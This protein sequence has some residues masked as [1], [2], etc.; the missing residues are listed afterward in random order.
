MKNFL[1]FILALG[2][3]ALALQAQ[4]SNLPRD[5]FWVTDGEVR[6][7][8]ETN[9]V[10][11]VGG[12]F[13]YVSP[14]SETGAAFD[15]ISGATLFDFPKFAGTIKVI[16]GDNAGGWFVGGQFASVGG[17]AIA[18]LAHILS[19]H[20]VDTNWAPNPDGSVLSL[21]ISADKLFVGGTFNHIGGKEHSGLAALDPVLSTPMENWTCNL[22]SK[23]AQASANALTL[24][25]GLLYVGGLFS[26]VNGEPR[27]HLASVRA[28]DGAVTSWYPNGQTGAEVSTR[29]NA[30]A[31]ADKILYVGGTFTSIGSE[32]SDGTARGFLAAM[33]TTTNLPY[34]VTSWNP[35]ANGPVT[36]IAI[37]CDTVYVAGSFTS[38]GGKPRNRLAAVSIYDGTPTAWD[39]NADNDVLSLTLAGNTIYVGGKFSHV[40]GQ[41]RNFLAALDT[42]TGTATLWNPKS[43]FGVAG[44]F[45]S[46]SSI[47]A[48]GV[49]GPGGELRHNAAAFNTRTGKPLSWSPQV[50]GATILNVAPFEGVK[51]FSTSSNLVY[52]GGYF[53]KVDELE[54]KRIATFNA[55]SGVLGAWKPSIEGFTETIL[56]GAN[57][58][59]V[60]GYFSSAAGTMRT[61]LAALD[62]RTGLTLP[63]FDPHPDGKVTSLAKTGR[64]LYAAGNFTKIGGRTRKHLAA[65]DL[66][67]GEPSLWNPQVNDQVSSMALSGNRLYV[68]GVFTKIGSEAV[69]G[70]AAVDT[71]TGEATCWRPEPQFRSEAKN[72]GINAIVLSGNLVYVA[73]TFDHIGGQ[74][75]HSL[76]ALTTECSA[77]A[78]EWDPNIGEAVGTIALSRDSLFAGG[79]FQTVGGVYRPSLAVFAPVGAPRI[80][81]QPRSQ[82]VGSGVP[83]LLS[84]L[85]EG[86][87]PLAFQWEKDGVPI[88]GANGPALSLQNPNASDSGDYTLIVTNALGLVSSR[89]AAL[90]ILEPVSITAQ[91]SGATVAAGVSLNLT[92]KVSGNPQPIYQWRKNG[93]NI[94][95]AIFSTLLL[96]NAQPFDGG[97]YSV[98]VLGLRNA[99]V[100]SNA[101]VIVQAPVLPFEDQLSSR[102]MLV[103]ESG[104]GSGNN[105]TATAEPFEP[106]HARKFGGKSVWLS[107]QAPATGV[108]TFSTA[109]SGFDTLLGIYTG[110]SMGALVP[111]AAD[112][113]HGGYLTSEA[114][115]DAVAGTEYLIAVDGYAGQSGNIVLRWNLQ[116][117][118][119]SFPRIIR[120][121]LSRSVGLG[122]SAR[123]S[124]EA[125]NATSYQ[126][127]Y[128][129]R[130]IPEATNADL[131]IPVTGVQHVG[132]YHVEVRNT[133]EQPLQSFEASLDIG[134]E[135]KIVAQEKLED[136]FNPNLTQN[137][138]L[139][140]GKSIKSDF[141]LPP[142]VLAVGLGS[143]A[144][145]TLG[146]A[147]QAAS[148]I[149]DQTMIVA[150][151][152]L[153]LYTTEAGIMQVDTIGSTI[154][155]AMIIYTTNSTYRIKHLLACDDNGAPDH[156]RSQLIFPA[157]KES[158]YLIFAGGVNGASGTLKL[159]WK[160]D[161]TPGAVHPSGSWVIANDA[162]MLLSADVLTRTLSP[163]KYQWR[164]NGVVVPGATNKTF[165]IAKATGKN[166]G[167]YDVIVQ[168]FAGSITMGVGTV[169]VGGSLIPL[170]VGTAP[171]LDGHSYFQVTGPSS[172]S[173]I[174]QYATELAQPPEYTQWTSVLTNRSSTA[175]PIS[176]TDSQS[177]T[178]AQRFYRVVPW[179]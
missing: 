33:N 93:I 47:A 49:L 3:N 25:D 56:P 155:T 39:P 134:P 73:G 109:G 128:G 8:L 57:A 4:H 142:G 7:V 53:T 72:S 23:L 129:C 44:L 150:P 85:A 61:N 111:I 27:E 133:F 37:A 31:I 81:L 175:S 171:G 5:D 84:G 54:R 123:F 116:E 79:R 106:M 29:I 127:F 70:L 158:F 169:Y 161:T 14:V 21:A 148:D 105:R 19:D 101:E 40:G 91:P 131:I 100:S 145:Q 149:C 135:T 86:K 20:S 144:S 130:A 22:S 42:A 151:K 35:D 122:Q 102:H 43:D 9:G 17:Y 65:L 159:N 15:P 66:T 13:D 140:A 137:D 174:L 74:F 68:G 16:Q 153:A 11:Y 64:T 163:L 179:N 77:G 115:F 96:T 170:K 92:V 138:R 119:K 18:N 28:L 98:I 160:M 63:G 1:F 34:S 152:Y 48:G 67:S 107:W 132:S 139:A 166:A 114:V 41:A 83:V 104:F 32:V 10:L 2:L 26:Y 165:A 12:I 126:W 78:T 95:G 143:I 24:S 76:A 97:I 156:I 89:P 113:D 124:V 38:V 110:A 112:E 88:P 87:P 45:V 167:F 125:T 90:T 120:Q 121:P 162:P 58:I 176:F 154:D 136:L 51:T 146:T 80:V 172:K 46:G 177:R 99:V 55:V 52:M 178:Q 141:A 69:H 94:P 50:A 164:L 59:Y 157:E 62:P 117:S 103:G 36:A 60:G 75:R 173:N 71:A 82:L 30:M 6:A 147:D 118:D 168:N 108:A